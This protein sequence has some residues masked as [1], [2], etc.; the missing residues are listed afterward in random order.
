LSD[1]YWHVVETM[2]ASDTA[3]YEVKGAV[4]ATARRPPRATSAVA[5]NAMVATRLHSTKY[6][7]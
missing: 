6:S 2:L 3:A 7:E 1:S 5:A 4:G